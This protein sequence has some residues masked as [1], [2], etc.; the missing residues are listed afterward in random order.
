MFFK[1]SFLG[2]LFWDNVE[3]EETAEKEAEEAEKAKRET[4]SEQL[5]E[6]QAAEPERPPGHMLQ[7]SQSHS[8]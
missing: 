3:D 8:F 7:L 1:N 2:R 6:E 4:G 5:Q